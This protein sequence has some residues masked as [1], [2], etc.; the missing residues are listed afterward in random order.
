MFGISIWLIWMILAA[1]FIVGE[2]FTAGFFIMWFGIG[3]AV[4]GILALLGA[5]PGWQ[6]AAFVLVSLVLVL[7]SR[8]FANKI[9]KE[10]P[11]GIGASRF[12][13]KQG[14]VL[15]EIDNAKGTGRI[16]MDR[17]E[18]RAESEDGHILPAGER[19]VTVKIEGTHLIV[20]SLT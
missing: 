20:K 17:E 1:M 19:V 7:V 13:G 4:A 12:V 11:P 9:T 6:L 5:D 18:W 10:Q 8:K 15:E 16:R 3:A 14:V 2:I